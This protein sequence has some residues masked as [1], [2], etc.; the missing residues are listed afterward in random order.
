VGNDVGD[1]GSVEVG[2]GPVVA[3]NSGGGASVG[4]DWRA[5]SEGVAQSPTRVV[6]W[7]LEAG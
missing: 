3:V 7:V 2:V 5:V 4:A 1:G 6:C